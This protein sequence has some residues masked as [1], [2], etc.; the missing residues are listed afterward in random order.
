MIEVLTTVAH[1]GAAPEWVRGYDTEFD[2][3]EAQMQQHPGARGMF[4]TSVDIESYDE[5][6]TD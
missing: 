2:D 3:V 5:A 1:S 6:T 4:E